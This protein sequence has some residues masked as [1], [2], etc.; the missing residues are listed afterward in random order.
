MKGNKR[1]IGERAVKICE[2]P[3]YTHQRFQGEKIRPPAIFG[4]WRRTSK[5]DQLTSPRGTSET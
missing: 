1:R 4:V 2:S 3:S 5:K